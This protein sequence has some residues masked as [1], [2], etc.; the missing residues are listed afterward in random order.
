MIILN[1]LK[2]FLLYFKK[3]CKQIKG[4]RKLSQYSKNHGYR[5]GN[6]GNGISY[7]DTYTENLTKQ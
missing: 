7:S 6:S 4:R 1:K 5:F 2:N 3:Y